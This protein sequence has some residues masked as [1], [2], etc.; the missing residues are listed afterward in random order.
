MVN[1][2]GLEV[3][4]GQAL[5]WFP[6]MHF[7]GLLE[8]ASFLDISSVVNAAWRRLPIGQVFVFVAWFSLLFWDVGLF[9]ENLRIVVKVS[10]LFGEAVFFCGQETG[11]RPR[12]SVYAVQ[13]LSEFGQA[14]FKNHFGAWVPKDYC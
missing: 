12:K 4:E 11:K 3:V 7:F 6:W 1:D 2:F 8:E 9:F 13:R 10:V 5:S 14:F